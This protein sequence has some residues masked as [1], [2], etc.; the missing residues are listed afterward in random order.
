MALDSSKKI[1]RR[2]WDV[3]PMLDVVIIQVNELGRD[4]PEQLV[5]TDRRGHLTGDV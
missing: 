4:Q 3:I 2:G 1:M 5:F